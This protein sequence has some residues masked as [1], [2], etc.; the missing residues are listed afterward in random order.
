MELEE[1]C[2]GPNSMPFWCSIEEV[3]DTE[4]SVS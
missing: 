1:G 3:S 4:T 2:Y